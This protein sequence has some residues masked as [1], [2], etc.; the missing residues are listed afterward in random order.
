[1]SVQQGDFDELKNKL[2]EFIEKSNEEKRK[3]EEEKKSTVSLN[4]SNILACMHSKCYNYNTRM[5]LKKVPYF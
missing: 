4:F 1:M 3:N 2:D 5:C